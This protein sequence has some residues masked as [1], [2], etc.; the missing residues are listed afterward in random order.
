MG[1]TE[2]IGNFPKS[3]SERRFLLV[4]LARHIIER[5]SGQCRNVRYWPLAY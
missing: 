2:R 5:T 4:Q 3:D 1:R